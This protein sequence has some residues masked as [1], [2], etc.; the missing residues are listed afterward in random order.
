MGHYDIFFR[1]GWVLRLYMML[2]NSSN[3][4]KVTGEWETGQDVI[5]AG[6]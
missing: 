2:A 6:R 4:G 3:D 1:S 5:K